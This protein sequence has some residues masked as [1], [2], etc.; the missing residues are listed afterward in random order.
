VIE[1][2]LRSDTRDLT[3][4]K[5]IS[6]EEIK[7]IASLSM[8]RVPETE[9]ELQTLKENIQSMLC[10]VERIQQIDTTNVE[11]LASLLE[12]YRLRTRPDVPNP[13]YLQN[14]NNYPQILRN[15]PQTHASFFVVPKQ[16]TDFEEDI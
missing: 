15:A 11:P 2:F 16:K 13:E 7:R 8:L 1:T 6:D 4:S 5:K 12:K 10:C 14:E 9:R 3:S